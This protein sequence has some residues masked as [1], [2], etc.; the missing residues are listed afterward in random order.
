MDRLWYSK[1]PL[2]A[3][4][5]HAKVNAKNRSAK[6]VSWLKYGLTCIYEHLNA[7]IRGVSNYIDKKQQA[8]NELD[9]K[10]WV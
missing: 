9:W 4:G 5:M 1:F 3:V 10:K 7:F 6:W 2:T 8:T